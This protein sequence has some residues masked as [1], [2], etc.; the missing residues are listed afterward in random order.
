MRN[1]DILRLLGREWELFVQDVERYEKILSDEIKNSSFLVI[2]G[3]GSIGS[4][5]VKEFFARNPRVLHVIDIDENGLAELVRDIR[6]SLGYIDG[7]FQTFCIDFGSDIFERFLEDKGPYDYILN[8]CALKHVRSEKDPYTLMR[9]IDVNILNNVKLLER[10]TQRPPK[11]YFAV[12]TD[13]A[14]NPVNMMGASKRI[15]EFFL[16]KYSTHIN[17]STAR[18]AN[19][20]FSKGSLL[21]S[22]RYRIEKRQPLVAPNDV[23]RYFITPKESG[24][25]CMMSAILGENME[26]FFPKLGE[27]YMRRFDELAVKYLEYLGYTPHICSSEQ[28]ARELAHVLPEQKKWPCYFFKSDTTG[29][30]EYEEFYTPDEELNL[31]KFK[32]I[33]IVKSSANYNEEALDEFL[34]QIKR[35]KAKSWTKEEIVTLFKKL[36]PNF[37]H[38][39]T[40]K[41]LDQKM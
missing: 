13:K 38:K 15:M 19:V 26:L 35:L 28:E 7:D 37:E 6:S 1:E 36:V 39:E 16:F 21:D 9:M 24:M 40:G 34:H 31:D 10:L 27:E 12:S 30:K 32:D 8:F 3:A 33:G 18:F 41:N 4:A 11:K 22:F 2:G 23:L 14:T 17:V 25:L 20:A 5:T 29:E